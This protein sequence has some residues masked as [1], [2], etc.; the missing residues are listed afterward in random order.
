MQLLYMVPWA[1]RFV[2][3]NKSISFYH[4]ACLL[5]LPHNL[6]WFGICS[7]GLNGLRAIAFPGGLGLQAPPC[8]ASALGSP[9]LTLCSY[10]TQSDQWALGGGGS[11]FLAQG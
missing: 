6:L 10:R 4:R 11:Q 9:S 3:E 8:P 7:S 2:H 5:L 1:D